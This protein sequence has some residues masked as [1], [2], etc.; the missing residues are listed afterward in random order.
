MNEKSYGR[1]RQ[2]FFQG[3]IVNIDSPYQDGSCQIRIYG[4]EDDKNAI[5]D[6][7]LR[8]AKCLMPVTHGQIGGSG[9]THGLQKGS[10][11]MGMFVDED[12]Q[13]PIIMGAWSSTGDIK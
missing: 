3:E 5:P 9:G 7:K 1:G 4:L 12:E 11:V 13:I 6:D 10:K 8:W 2:N